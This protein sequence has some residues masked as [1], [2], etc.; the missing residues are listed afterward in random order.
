MQILMYVTNKMHAKKSMYVTNKM[1]A[2]I[3]KMKK[4]YKMHANNLQYFI[5]FYNMHANFNN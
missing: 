4:K 1:H 5:T 3:N 2:S